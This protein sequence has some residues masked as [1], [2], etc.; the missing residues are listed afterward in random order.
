M[1][2]LSLEQMENLQGGKQWNW[3]TYI[4][5]AAG[6][7]IGAA[8]GAFIVPFGLVAGA[9]FLT[10]CQVGDTYGWN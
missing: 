10:V 3:E 6:V 1:K 8:I 2:T 7:G 9:V 4:C 5:G